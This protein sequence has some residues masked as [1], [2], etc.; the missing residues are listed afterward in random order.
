M[1]LNIIKLSHQILPLSCFLEK[2]N[3]R[4]ITTGYFNVVML[5][6]VYVV[7]NENY[8]PDPVNNYSILQQR[9][10]S[11]FNNYSK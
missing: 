11:I 5:V 1:R 2:F 7:S 6:A 4:Q 9:P 3:I 10:S 8:V